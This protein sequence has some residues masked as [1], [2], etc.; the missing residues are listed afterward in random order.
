MDPYTSYY[1]NQAKTGIGAHASLKQSGR[2]LGSFISKIFTNVYPYLK[3]GISAIGNELLS[4]GLGLIKDTVNQVPIKES[5]SNRAKKVGHSLTDR[6]VNSVMGM[7]GSGNT[8]T[9][10]RKKGTQSSARRTSSKKVKRAPKGGK[11]KAVKKKQPKKCT[12]KPKK[13]QS[14]KGVNDIFC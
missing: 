14:G 5:I 11:K 6:A 7:S 4:G 3:S 9:R 2:G 1:L 13:R 12:K 8:N 10:K